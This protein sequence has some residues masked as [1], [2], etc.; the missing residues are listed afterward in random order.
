M[1]T[2]ANLLD[3]GFV[4]WVLIIAILCVPAL[5]FLRAPQR[6]EVLPNHSTTPS[7]MRDNNTITE[8]NQP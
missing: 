7:R 8:R 5:P 1:M 2:V 3:V 4:L 6:V